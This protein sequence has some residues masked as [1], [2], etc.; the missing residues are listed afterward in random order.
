MKK[1]SQQKP[2][3]I[4]I[5]GKGVFGVYFCRMLLLGGFYCDAFDLPPGGKLDKSTQ[6]R[7]KASTVVIF[8]VPIRALAAALRF[9]EPFI[10]DGCLVM[11][12][13]SIKVWPAAKLKEAFRKRKKVNLV[14]T[15]PLFG[16]KSAPDN[17]RGQRIAVC[18]IKCRATIFRERLLPIV[19]KLGLCMI[20]CDPHEH[21]RQV[22]ESQALN[23]FLGRGAE[24][25]GMRQVEMSTKTHTLF[26]EIVRIIV[27]GNPQ[28]LFEDMTVFNPYARSAREKFM[29]RLSFVD[30]SLIKL[31]GSHPQ[32]KEIRA[33]A[34]TT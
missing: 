4:T 19:E 24:A 31:E 30:Q 25:Y 22:A 16:P 2:A 3:Q 10:P 9:Y 14:A 15:H 13:C 18:N 27:A 5:I 34:R 23:H 20:Q 21:D 33:L 17:C 26:M 32:G 8:A 12:V 28:E 1:T 7:L 11:D 6:E 29:E